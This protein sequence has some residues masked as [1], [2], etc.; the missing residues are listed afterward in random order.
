MPEDTDITPTWEALVPIF[1]GVLQNEEAPV[2]AHREAIANLTQMA[3]LADRYVM[4]VKRGSG[5]TV[6]LTPTLGDPD[7]EPS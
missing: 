4:L 5:D 3:A 1:V 6:G 7:K 2:T